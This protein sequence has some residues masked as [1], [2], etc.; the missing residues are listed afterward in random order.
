AARTRPPRTARSE[1]ARNECIRGDPETRKPSSF[2]KFF[3]QADNSRRRWRPRWFADGRTRAES[4]CLDVGGVDFDADGLSDQ[5]DRE[6]EA[7]LR[8]ILAHQPSD[9]AF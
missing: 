9:D 8:R 2:R 6:H 3:L 7:R 4:I 1:L 5:I